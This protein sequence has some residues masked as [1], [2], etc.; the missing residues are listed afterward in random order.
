MM[1]ALLIA[2]I[3]FGASMV[4]DRYNHNKL[5]LPGF[6][7]AKIARPLG[8]FAF[9]DAQGNP[10]T[11]SSFAGNVLVLNFWATWCAPCVKEMPSLD[12]LAAQTKGQGI[13]VIPVAQQRQDA[14]K[15]NA[16]YKEHNITTL[17]IYFDPS[18][19]GVQMLGIRGLPTTFIL[20]AHGNLMGTYEGD[21]DWAA[22]SIIPFLEQFKI[23][24]P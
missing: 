19:M 6:Q 16:F 23:P 20:D 5:P 3:I 12:V 13:V 10:V 18:L 1:R 15:I 21:A 7:Y 14:D 4:W 8:G 22:P 11:V 17:G 2:L 24:L 9:L